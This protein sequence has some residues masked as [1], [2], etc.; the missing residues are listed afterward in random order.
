MAL[1]G[2][3]GGNKQAQP[4]QAAQEPF[5][6]GQ[7][8]QRINPE[9]LAQQQTMAQQQAL[10][11]MDFSP[12]EGGF[13]GA[14]GRGLQGTVGGIGLRNARRD[15]NTLAQQQE[16]EKQARTQSVAAAL[17]KNGFDQETAQSLAQ[18][19]G[20]EAIKAMVPQKP[21]ALP[22]I[23]RL[24]QIADDPN[25]PQ[26]IRD[27]ATAR[28]QAINDPVQNIAFGDNFF[29]ARQSQMPSLLGAAGY[30]AVQSSSELPT[31]P[32]GALTPIDPREG[33]PAPQTGSSGIPTQMTRAQYQAI[34]ASM[35]EAKAREWLSRN[36][37][38][39]ID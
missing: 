29:S 36:P 5:V 25:Q 27:T 18:Y 9:Q 23:I 28:I 17:L 37:I 1:F 4:A 22:E 24:Q 16:A 30:G 35:G 15:A 12:V 38:Q 33:V 8:G 2:L 39:V 21:D 20:D 3:L 34:I 10:A 7:G 31:A 26:S 32:V 19:G 13:L 6:W 14:L 11:G